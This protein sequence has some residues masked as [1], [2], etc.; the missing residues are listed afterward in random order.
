MMKIKLLKYPYPYKAW[1]TL[2]NDPDHTTLERWNKLHQLIWSKLE[3]P[4]SDSL[5]VKSYNDY[6]PNQ[7]NLFEHRQLI[8]RHSYDTI[9]TWGD[10]VYSKDK[11]FTRKDAVEA[12]EI[13]NEFNIKPIIW[14][15][16][17]SFTGNFIKNSNWGT[18]TYHIDAAGHKYKNFVYTLDLAY[19]LGIRY[20]WDGYLVQKLNQQPNVFRKKNAHKVI[21]D[22]FY[23]HLKGFLSRIFKVNITRDE[24][25]VL[26]KYGLKIIDFDDG[27]RMY[28]FRRCGTWNEAHIDGIP[29]IVNEIS[30]N[31]LVKNG[32]VCFLY[33]HL[34]KKMA[35]ANNDE[36]IT[37][38][39]IDSFSL[40]KKYY[41]DKLIN[42]SSFSKLLDYI[43]LKEYLSINNDR[44]ELKFLPDGIRYA[45]LKSSDLKGHCFS[46]MV[47][48]RFDTDNLKIYVG[49]D[50]SNNH[51]I[52]REKSDIFTVYFA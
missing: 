5:F 42:M 41:E 3:L 44:N 37:K 39:T 6:V 28:S 45:N 4:F 13:I 36:H 51:K 10:Y 30:L 11:V 17:S 46:F 48:K 35:D 24:N 15:D 8:M 1:F 31:K 7:I 27:K 34:G 49:S 29:K 21:S 19:D 18:K 26:K 23:K 47:N 33:T 40:L 12:V 9:H 25:A 38:E 16:H 52:V 20:V 22:F 43:I 14:V 2:S 32:G 50:L